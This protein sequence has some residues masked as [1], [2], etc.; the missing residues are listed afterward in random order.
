MSV[1]VQCAGFHEDGS[2]QNRCQIMFALDSC[3]FDFFSLP[4][5]LRSTRFIFGK[6]AGNISTND[7]ES[8]EA[9][10]HGCARLLSNPKFEAG[11]PVQYALTMCELGTARRCLNISKHH[12]NF[13][14]WGSVFAISHPSR[15]DVTTRL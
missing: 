1:Q 8:E 4:Q 15:M 6:G 11:Q 2:S 7:G 10:G 13:D 12:F 3:K 5:F 9:K 14:F